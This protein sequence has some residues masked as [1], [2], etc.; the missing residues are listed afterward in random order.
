[1]LNGYMGKML[2]V[3][4]THN[5]IT[6]EALDE[7]MCRDYLG[8]YGLGAK[9]LFDRQ[10]PGVDALGPDNI[11]GFLT[12]TL[13]GTQSLAASRYV[14][15]GKSPLTGTW[16][17]AN[18]GGDFGPRMKLAGYDAVFFTGISSKPV[19]LLIDSGKAELRDA[20]KLWGKDSWDTE[21]MLQAELGKDTEVA[22][23]GPS[24]EKLALIAAVIN[25]KG[26]AA[27]R[28]GLGAVMGSKK[29]KAIAVKG[30]LKVPVADEAKIAEMRKTLIPK[31]GGPVGLFRAIG[32]PGILA[33]CTEHGDAP[34]KNWGGAAVTD[35]PTFNKIAG[36]EVIAKQE[37][38]YACYRCPVGC[39]GE[40][41]EGTG[42]YKYPAGS[43]KPEY[44]TLA[45]FGPSCLN[46][47]LDAIIKCND[48][49][50]RYG[51][52]TISA[53]STISF[54]IE[55]YENGL[56]TKEDTNGIEMTWGNHKSMVTMLEKLAKREG[57][58]NIL[59]D[60]TK[61]A[62]AKIGKGAEKFAMNMGGQ[63]YGAH[64]PRGNYAFAICYKMD[65][66]PG[67]H[68]R[69][70]GAGFEG[71]NKPP[72]DPQSYYGR[73][74]AQRIGMSFF[75]VIDSLGC[76]Q[77]ATMTLPS[78]YALM[79][80]VNATTGWNLTVDDA[81]KIGERIANIR[82]AFNL[83]E[84]YNPL[85]VKNPGRMVGNPPVKAGPTAGKTVDED[86]IAREFCE[87]MDWDPVT[88]KPSKKKLAELGMDDVAKVIW[89]KK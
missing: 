88:A 66:T 11:L 2:W 33:P 80:F 55:C 22:C 75:H 1:M 56:I 77:F 16:G 10:K 31:L 4:L 44:E 36:N 54:A 37:K 43:H 79:D 89:D 71:L 8:G 85:N 59:A 29:L 6:E 25:N 84:G 87:A 12:G 14:V 15:V 70:S 45:M 61:K 50:N 3:D 47:N 38:R 41:K 68:T 58:G 42:E 35:F 74:P 73:G 65:A 81:V 28:S 49:C 48:I 82:H 64:D 53:G 13:S 40:M 76:C 23:I 67:R 26:R 39:G 27:A 7:K 62:A 19:Y 46:D 57:F 63:E 86:R 51:L 21:D 69:D 24:G 52:D 18:S 5:K 72:F 34:V 60:G 17:D 20:A 83:R 9:I 78:A 30:N 32:T